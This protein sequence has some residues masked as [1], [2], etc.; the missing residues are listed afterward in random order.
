[1]VKC[2]EKNSRIENIMKYLVVKFHITDNVTSDA[3][4]NLTPL[5]SATS[6]LSVTL[7]TYSQVSYQPVS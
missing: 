7:Y 4:I 6:F 1:M 3:W 2:L 5:G